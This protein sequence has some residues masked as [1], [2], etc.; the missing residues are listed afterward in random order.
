MVD[1]R[2]AGGKGKLGGMSE[3]RGL[4]GGRGRVV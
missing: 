4:F 2:D 3:E 1:S